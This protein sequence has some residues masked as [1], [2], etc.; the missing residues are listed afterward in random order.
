M[1]KRLGW[2]VLASMLL[3][4]LIA[5]A[6]QPKPQIAGQMERIGIRCTSGGTCVESWNGSDIVLY[7]DQG[8]TQKVLI[9]GATGAG[10]WSGGQTVNNWV[11]V[12]A[13]PAA[14]AT[15]QVLIQDVGAGVPLEVRNASATPV[16][17]VDG[18]YNLDVA[19][20]VNYGSND[21]YPLGYGSDGYQI[22]VGST[23]ITG[24]ANVSHG[25]GTSVVAAG[26]TLAQDPGT[27]VGD[28]AFCSVAVSGTTVTVKV[29]QD[30]FTA[31]TNAATVN[32]WVVGQP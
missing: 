13:T 17:V 26:C 19:G 15:P 22:V 31:A 10:T 24:S 21:L 32:W 18:S 20:S 25:L 1:D 4:V 16:V 29:W 27:G 23:S 3:A 14:T 5:A 8:S 11:K 30:D 6:C 7:S 12:A 2:V 28:G 9:D